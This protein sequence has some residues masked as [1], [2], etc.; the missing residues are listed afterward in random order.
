MR[1]TL[2][3]LLVDEKEWKDPG[4]FIHQFSKAAEKLAEAEN[5][6]A[7]RTC[8]PAA[9]T[10][11]AWYYGQRTPNR[12]ARRVLV[13]MFGHSIERLWGAADGPLP[14]TSP[15]NDRAIPHAVLH[16]MRKGAEMAARR[17]REFALGAEQG[18]L[19]DETL[20]F[21]QDEVKRIAGIYQRV[22]LSSVF[23]DLVRAQEDV[24]RLIEGGR[25]RPTQLRQLQI[26]ATLLS[27]FM[28]KAG[29]DM[30]DPHTAMMQARTA[31][32]CAQQAEHPG[33]M[34]L[35]DGL[36]S[37]ITYWTGQADDALFYARKGAAEHPELRGSVSV[38][39]PSLE[40]RAAALLGNAETVRS[41][42]LRA[43]ES[44]EHVVPDD[45]DQLGGLLTFPEPKQLYYTAESHVL[46]GQGDAETAEQAQ[47]AAAAFS[48]RSTEHWA[49]GDEA[50][51]LCNL[52]LVRLYGGDLDGTADALRPVLDLPTDQRNRGIV[53]SAQRVRTAL[54][55]GPVRTAA[56][57]RELREEI[58]Q[59]SP[60][61]LALP[62]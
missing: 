53:V 37:L 1:K 24:F 17:A 33:L 44:R 34:A 18:Q 62:H 47:R 12:D 21:L 28:A 3:R 8:T 42:N 6:P 51:A 61:R 31:G 20:G 27:W 49:F 57:A 36:K 15:A 55:Q 4:A 48:D 23:G 56:V 41:A 19:G 35:V 52:S 22:P 43:A 11:E 50:G 2:F 46:L 26:M 16:E 39:L 14:S 5:A 58:G 9:S 60:T 7:L 29:H 25:H 10:F 54:A 30:D 38:W 45:L 40:A 13:S 59:F 32:V